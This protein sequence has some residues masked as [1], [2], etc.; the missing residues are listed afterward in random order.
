MRNLCREF[1]HPVVGL[2]PKVGKDKSL[3]LGLR[4]D[5][6]DRICTGNGVSRQARQ[7]WGGDLGLGE[8]AALNEYVD[9]SGKMF[10][11]FAGD[12]VPADGERF[13]FRFQTVA[14]KHTALCERAAE[15]QPTPVEAL[16][17]VPSPVPAVVYESSPHICTHDG[18]AID[19]ERAG[20]FEG[21]VPVVDLFEQRGHD[22]SSTGRTEDR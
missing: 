21:D 9:V 6:T 10:Q 12:A 11:P 20:R 5:L 8:V 1:V 19:G 3:D 13:S 4:R 16:L 7:G 17:R 14:E 2:R 22:P 18:R 15:V